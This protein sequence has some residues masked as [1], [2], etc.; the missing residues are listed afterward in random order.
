MRGLEPALVLAALALAAHGAWRFTA[1]PPDAR[2]PA[3]FDIA[4]AAVAASAVLFWREPAQ[5]GEGEGAGEVG[6]PTPPRSPAR[7]FLFYAVPAL[8]AAA[9]LW[10]LTR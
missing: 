1:G 3:L 2:F 7:E 4:L 6:A 10:F 8:G 5:P 9:V